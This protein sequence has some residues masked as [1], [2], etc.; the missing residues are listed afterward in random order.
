MQF[1]E[2]LEF[3]NISGHSLVLGTRCLRF[4]VY[5]NVFYLISL[6]IWEDPVAAKIL[7]PKAYHSNYHLKLPAICRCLFKYLLNYR[8]ALPRNGCRIALVYACQFIHNIVSL[9]FL[10]VYQHCKQVSSIYGVSLCEWEQTHFCAQIQMNRYTHINNLRNL[11]I[12]GLCCRSQ[13]M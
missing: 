6:K 13:H 10:F 4:S 3:K 5:L 9:W 1:S 2:E 11:W 8:C 12:V 7:I